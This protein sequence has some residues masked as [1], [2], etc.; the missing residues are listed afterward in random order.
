MTNYFDYNQMIKQVSGLN[1]V[2]TLKKWRLKIEQL[3]GHTFQEDRIRTGKRSYS[4]VFLFT[5]D[6][7]EKLQQIADTKGNLGLDKAILKSYAPT[8]ASL[9]SVNQKSVA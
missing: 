1:S 9:L 4:K 5:A 7:I 3:T 2:S 8:R 6:D